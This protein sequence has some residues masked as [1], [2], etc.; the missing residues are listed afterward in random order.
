MNRTHHV[1]VAG[2]SRELPISTVPTGVRLAVFNII[3]TMEQ[4]K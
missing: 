3:V 1:E 2:L 4:A